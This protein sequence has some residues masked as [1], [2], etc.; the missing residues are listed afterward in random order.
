MRKKPAICRGL[1]SIHTPLHRCGKPGGSGL[2]RPRFQAFSDP[3]VVDNRPPRA[4][5]YTASPPCRGRRVFPPSTY[6]FAHETHL[7]A[8][9][10]QAQAQARLPRTHGDPRRPGDPQAPPSEGPQ[11][12]FGVSR[13]AVQRRHRLSRSRDFDAVYRQGRSVSTRYLVLYTF[14]RDAEPGQPRLG[15]AVPKAVGTGS[16]GSYARRGRRDSSEFRRVATTCS[17]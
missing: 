1:D 9:R 14:E 16:S 7:P 3:D 4:L 17:R 13:Q 10:T 12:S 2:D 8:E 15:L 5:V 6:L 11:A